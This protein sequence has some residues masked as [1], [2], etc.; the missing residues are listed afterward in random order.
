MSTLAATEVLLSQDSLL[1][2]AKLLN[3]HV[4]VEFEQQS[5]EAEEV[6]YNMLADFNPDITIGH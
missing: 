6:Y 3:I 5:E 4:K 2:A 1:L